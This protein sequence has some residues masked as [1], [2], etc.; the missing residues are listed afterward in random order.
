MVCARACA[1]VYV[2]VCVCVC[3]HVHVRVRVG[4]SVFQLDGRNWTGRE[5]GDVPES[6]VIRDVDGHA[7][8]SVV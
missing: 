3:V 7:H 5:K 6:V 2:C 8:E 1:C 4:R